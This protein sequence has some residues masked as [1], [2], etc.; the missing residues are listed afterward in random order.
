MSVPTIRA[1]AF[2]C[3]GTVF[4]MREFPRELIRDYAD[5][6]RKD[7][8][9]PFEFPVVWMALKA[10][11]D[12]ADGIAALQAA[13]I[14]CVAFSNGSAD[15]IWS[16]GAANGIKWSGVIDMVEHG[17][18][19]PNAGAYSI[20]SKHLGLPPSEIAMVTANKDFGDLEGA[21]GVGMLPVLIRGETGRTIEA[22]PQ[23]FRD[24]RATTFL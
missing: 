17:V 22:L 15:L 13:G 11:P 12:A 21:E 14:D 1:A 24:Q 6:V 19:K 16:L 2:D 5:H 10:F 9:E 18:Y 7:V 23:Y 4:D 3:F 8:F 20:P